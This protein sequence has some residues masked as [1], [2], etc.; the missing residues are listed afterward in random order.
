MKNKTLFARAWVAFVTV[1][2]IGTPFFALPATAQA[3]TSE[4]L[5]NWILIGAPRFASGPQEIRDYAVDPVNGATLFV[6][7][8][9]VVMRSL[10]LGCEWEQVYALPAAGGVGEPSS[11]TSEIVRVEIAANNHNRI[12]LG[13]QEG[14]AAGMRPHILTSDDTGASW[15]PGVGLPPQGQIGQI[16]TPM[17]EGAAFVGIDVNGGTLDLLFASTDGGVSWT[18]RSNLHET[19]PQSGINGFTIDPSNP[20]SLWAHGSGSVQPG[21]NAPDAAGLLHSTNGGRSFANVEEFAQTVVGPVDVYSRSGTPARIAA[22]QPRQGNVA[23]SPD[24][25]QTWPIVDAPTAT[26]SVA[27]G[28]RREDD[29]VTAAGDL[30]AYHPPSFSWINLNAPLSGL[31][32]A[33]S[34]RR[35]FRYYARTGN[36]VVVY[37]GPR[38]P[39]VPKLP[40]SVF[41]VPLINPPPSIDRHPPTFTPAKRTVVIDPG[42][43][44]TLT[45]R[46]D[47]PER[48]LPLNV[49]FLL[50]TSDSMGSTIEDL[51]RSTA[52]IINELV[53]ENIDFKVG[54]GA[55][56]AYPDR[57]PPD[58]SCETTPTSSQRCEKNYVFRKIFDIQ[59]PGG[60][61][62][63]ALAELESDAGG[64]YKS[65][66]GALYQIATGAGQDLY[67]PGPA[68]HDVP[69]GLD[70]SFEDK[71][72]KVVL[73]AT[74]ERFGREDP[75][76]PPSADFSNPQSPE[77]PSFAE[78]AAALN[79]RDIH[80][81]GLSI[82]R[83]PRNDLERVARD[84]GALAPAEGVDCDGDGVEEIAPREPLVCALTRRNLEAESTNMVP[85]IVNL[86]QALPTGRN[87]TLDVKG[88]PEILGKISPEIHEDVVLQVANELVF[89][90]EYRCPISAAGKRFDF[91]LAARAETR[92]LLDSA[93]TRVICEGLEQAPPPL[94]PPLVLALI[95]PIP[96]PPPPPVSQ[97]T[98]S[99]QAQGQAQAQAGAAFQEEKQPQVAVAAAYKE[100]LEQ[101]AAMEYE[102]YNMTAYRP[103]R[104]PPVSPVFVLGVGLMM[105]AC[106]YGLTLARDRVQLAL[107]RDH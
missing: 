41:D 92:G 37:T 33:Q 101:R 95:P 50:D 5:D 6:T 76:D 75:S 40:D 91:K 51:A 96:P 45:Y 34:D 98:S 42:K 44:K 61:M 22:F 21:T 43:S 73:H 24:G 79:A 29:A 30:Y 8:G 102:S 57:F 16:F 7:N 25:G 14:A 105:G 71:A 26:D 20:E 46:L 39:P 103:R 31:V 38:I 89:D 99:T 59:P 60:T 28:E 13:I 35:L 36:A 67:P 72:L 81:I 12:F 77:I 15:T 87:V 68:G 84:T 11:A 1:A 49:F 54:I 93:T 106:A 55:F 53:E 70:V 2:L 9:K 63:Q 90:V 23:V 58:P 47:V 56:R 48:P 94:V 19:K 69:P 82:N 4:Q 62:S 78:V 85:A 83:A 10:R 65:H 27:H 80:Q 107:Q 52:N 64:K 100:M 66:L 18:L 74:D 104:E 32:D 97:L 88:N 3:C 17:V 86:L